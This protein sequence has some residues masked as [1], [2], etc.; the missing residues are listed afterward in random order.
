M[1]VQS[2]HDL[3]GC[4]GERVLPGKSGSDCT[5]TIG[6]FTGANSLETTVF[7]NLLEIA[8]LNTPV[9][10]LQHDGTI[11]DQAN[12]VCQL[13]ESNISIVINKGSSDETDSFARYFGGYGIPL[14][15]VSAT[16][17]QLRRGS[18]RIITMPPSDYYQVQAITQLLKKYGWKEV[19]LLAS[20]DG[21]GINGIVD[22]QRSLLKEGDF[23]LKNILIFDTYAESV[24]LEDLFASIRASLDRVIVYFGS[25]THARDIMEEAHRIGLMGEEFVWIVSDAVAGNINELAYNGAYRS[26]YQGLLGVRPQITRSQL[27]NDFHDNYTTRFPDSANHLTDY[28]LLFYDAIKLTDSV[29]SKLSLPEQNLSCDAENVS[30]SGGGEVFDAITESQYTGVTGNIEFTEDGQITDGVFDIVNF[31]GNAFVAVGSWSEIGGLQITKTP[32]FFNNSQSSPNGVANTL[33]G[34]HLRLGILPNMPFTGIRNGC[35]DRTSNSCFT[36][37]NIEIMELMAERLKFTYHFV[38]PEDGKFGGLD[39]DTN[40]WNGLVRDLMDNKTDMVVV[41]LSNNAA[42]KNVIDFTYPMFDGGLAA[43][44]KSSGIQR[45]I[46]FFFRPFEDSVWAT[47]MGICVVVS[48]GIYIFSRFSP[49]G[50]QGAQKYARNT[51][52]CEHCS[53][54]AN[55][56]ADPD[57]SACLVDTIDAADPQL[58]LTESLWLRHHGRSTPDRSNGRGVCV[59]CESYY[60]GLLGVRPQI[61]RSQLY[62]DF[63]DNYTTRFPDSANHLTDYALL[64]YDAIKLTD[65]VISKLSLP[66]QNLSCDAENVSWSGGGEVFDA[67]TESQ[68]TG[69]TGNIEFTEDG[70]ITDGVFD[71][72][73][74]VGNAFVAVGSWSEIGGLQITKTPTFFNNSQSSPNGVA[75]TL[76]GM[77]LRLGILPNMPFTGI[78][79]GCNDRTSNSCFTGINIEIMELMAERLKFTYH[80]VIPEDGKFGGLDP[81]TNQWNGLVRDLMDNK[82]DMVV[83]SLSNNAARKNVIDFTYPMFDGGLAA[84]VKSSGI[85]RDIFFFFR[86]FEDSVW[87]TIMGICVVVSGGI[88]IFSRFSPFG[89]Q[90]AQKYARNTCKCEHCSSSAN[91]P[92][93]PD[94]S[95]CL[96]DT[97]DAADPQLSL[98]ESLWLTSSALVGGGGDVLPRSLSGRVLLLTWW[99]FSL[100]LSTLYTANMAAFLTLNYRLTD[101]KSPLQLPTQTVYSWGLV[102]ST[103]VQ[104]LLASNSKTEYRVLEESAIKV[105]DIEEGYERLREGGFVFIHEI[106]EVGYATKGECDIVQVGNSFQ[107]FDLAFG[108]RKNSPFKNLIDTFMLEIREKGVID[109]LWAKYESQKV[110][111]SC[112]QT[113]SLTM[114]LV[115]LSGLFYAR[116]TMRE[117]HLQS[118]TLFACEFVTYSTLHS[119]VC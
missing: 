35:N 68:Y 31:V 111:S 98:T 64:F 81:D 28:A 14:L 45:D 79:N 36:G 88:Y 40:Q 67:I 119:V 70:Q 115:S 75:N 66:E 53:S 77:H 38:I 82:T 33:D 69:V 42:R 10:W 18:S 44:V 62:N 116:D 26:Y 37:I 114:D 107:P 12:V 76:D 93:D 106:P 113:K 57:K 99:F 94:K 71:I 46:F 50:S 96:V 102:G 97:L 118:P 104:T 86:P 73:N 60:Q 83:V 3:P 21:Y 87:A 7:Q 84:Y 95:A 17:S 109:G 78:R 39:P 56:P 51:C 49:F 52:K 54:S 24:D 55:S 100:L 8:E 25:V 92:A 61:T 85:Q 23:D 117:Y 112:L 48:G 72:V 5:P 30:W 91:S 2:D 4:L 9:V 27:Y 58:S 80:F 22:L 105:G 89:S 74:F 59:D 108:L 13:L 43:Y 6:I 101:L 110:A 16:I 90:G 47:I 34:M 19:T 103:N 29:I 11:R 32:T 41:S 65:S 20:N 1:D 63:H 15:S